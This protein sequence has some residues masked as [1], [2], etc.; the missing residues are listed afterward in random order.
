MVDISDRDAV[1]ALPEE[2]HGAHGQ[3][4]GLLERP[5]A[6]VV[7]VSSMGGFVPVSGQ[8]ID[9]ISKGSY[10]VVIG[11]DAKMLDRLSRLAPRR[12]AD[13][14]AKKMASLLG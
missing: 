9:G 11:S 1:A 3:V 5:E 6:C 2:V 7:H 4:D 13:L 12:A 14:V 8:T 10:R